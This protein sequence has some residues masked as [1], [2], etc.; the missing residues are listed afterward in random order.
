M[1]SAQAASLWEPTH[2]LIKSSER[3]EW[4]ATGHIQ[5]AGFY[6]IFVKMLQQDR[7]NIAGTPRAG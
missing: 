5:V 7:K 1:N 2:S 6:S 4:L 3:A